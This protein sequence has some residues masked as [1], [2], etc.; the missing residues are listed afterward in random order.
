MPSEDMNSINHYT[1][2]REATPGEK[3]LLGILSTVFSLEMN[4]EEKKERLTNEYGIEVSDY[5]FGQM[6]RMNP[7]QEWH[8]HDVEVA[9]EEGLE[10]GREEGRIE[11]CADNVRDLMS[12]DGI[13]AEEAMNRL[14]IPE[15]LRP[16]VLSALEENDRKT[17]APGE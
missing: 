5:L 14:K 6:E 4:A 17:V 9:R 10:A 1:I 12:S 8:D 7:I 15:D 3:R 13:N 11:T 2:R 16:K